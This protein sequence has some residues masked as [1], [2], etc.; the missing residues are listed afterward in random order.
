[1]SLAAMDEAMQAL[2]KEARET[3][4][5][6]LTLASGGGSF[7]GKVNQGYMYVRTVSHEERTLTPG[8]IW[9]GLIHGRPLDAFRGNYT[10]REVMM[11]L[12]QRFKKF[13]DMRT[14]VRNIAGFNIG[15]GTFDIDLALRGP[16][17]EKLAEYGEILKAKARD[18][19]GIVDID[20]TLRLHKPELPVAIDPQPA[21]DPRVDTPPISTPP[22][23]MVGGDDQVSRF[24]DPVVNDDYDVQI[25]L[26]PQ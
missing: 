26:M 6:A 25:R 3:K 1:M 19:G 16:E 9:N 14:Q 18:I 11:D 4:G 2:S 5:V 12:R 20:T 17:L 21:A 22:G 23:L 8:R 24:H 7:L 13:T 10:Q 15:R